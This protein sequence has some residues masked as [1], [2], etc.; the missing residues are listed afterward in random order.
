MKKGRF[1][2]EQMVGMLREADPEPKR[3]SREIAASDQSNPAA[4]VAAKA[5]A[6]IARCDVARLIHDA[7]RARAQ[8]TPAQAAFLNA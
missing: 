8:V 4:L 2:E 1:S 7:E 3:A 5:S 6:A